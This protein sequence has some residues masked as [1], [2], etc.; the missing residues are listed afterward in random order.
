MGCKLIARCFKIKMTLGEDVGGEMQGIL[1]S[2]QGSGR[3]PR[4]K[5]FTLSTFQTGTTQFQTL[6]SSPL[7]PRGLFPPF[8]LGGDYVYRI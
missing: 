1:C 7:Q 8:L 6:S 4:A 2:S 5:L 3:L